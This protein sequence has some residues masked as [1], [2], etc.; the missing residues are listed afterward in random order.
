MS[1]R[2]LVIAKNITKIS[3]GA[4]VASFVGAW[5][6]RPLP[7][8]HHGNNSKNG[9]DRLKEVTCSK[10]SLQDDPSV[11]PPF[12]YDIA[13]HITIFITTTITRFIMKSTGSFDLLKNSDYDKFIT[14]VQNLSEKQP[15]ITV[16][17]HRSLFDD[18]GVVSCL[19]P[20]EMCVQPKYQ[21]WGICSQVSLYSIVQI[22]ICR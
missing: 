8:I 7:D 9:P 10:T 16:S 3:F 18:P 21:R 14:A 2:F 6:Y 15:M 13:R 5:W 4:G 12:S 19:L 20:W 22:H 1:Q 11:S 17:N